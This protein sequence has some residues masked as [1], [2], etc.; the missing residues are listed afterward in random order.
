MERATELAGSG[1]PTPVPGADGAVVQIQEK[2]DEYGRIRSMGLVVSDD[3]VVVIDYFA[4]PPNDPKILEA[5]LTK[6]S[7][8]LH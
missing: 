8:L 5:L 3:L 2:G 7:Q 1:K 6:E 4:L